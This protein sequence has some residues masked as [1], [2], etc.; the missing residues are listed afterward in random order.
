MIKKSNLNNNN[1]INS[2]LELLKINNELKNI[3]NKDKELFLKEYQEVLDAIKPISKYV[4]K[5]KNKP[6]SIPIPIEKNSLFKTSD[7]MIKLINEDDFNRYEFKYKKLQKNIPLLKFKSIN[8]KPKIV[9]IFDKKQYKI[10][11]FNNLNAYLDSIP[12]IKIKYSNLEKQ[13]EEK[14]I[15]IEKIKNLIKLLKIPLDLTKIKN[16]VQLIIIINEED[17]FYN[18]RLLKNSLDIKKITNTIQFNKFDEE[19]KKEIEEIKE[20]DKI[21]LFMKKSKFE[22]NINSK[23]ESLES[24]NLKGGDIFTYLNNI[25][26]KNLLINNLEKLKNL[27]KIFIKTIDEFTLYYTQ[28]KYY[29]LFLIQK[30]KDIKITNKITILLSLDKI[31][32]CY[33]LFNDKYKIIINPKEYIFNKT[34]DLEIKK[35]RKKMFLQYYYQIYIIYHFLKFLMIKIINDL[36]ITSLITSLDNINID[37]YK[38]KFS[39][40]QFLSFSYDNDDSENKIELQKL[41][42]LLN[43]MII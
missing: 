35:K 39:N 27:N 18:I 31:F 34:L 26:K 3:N 24:F 10:P 32:N 21:N 11:D 42:I 22:I 30:L 38:D 20:I 19:N 40:S 17:I 23:L 15:K 36:N 8:F 5:I 14:I 9:D 1:L 2:Q 12:N 6:I 7:D 43:I 25:S 4:D 13:L 33:K 28:Y 29:Q 37:N 41:L 16:A